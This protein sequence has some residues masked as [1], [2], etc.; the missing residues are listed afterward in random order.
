[1]RTY[2]LDPNTLPP[3]TKAIRDTWPAGTPVTAAVD[4]VPTVQAISAILDA[5]HALET[6]VIALETP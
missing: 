5:V 4:T 6:R 3:L 1:M 2:D